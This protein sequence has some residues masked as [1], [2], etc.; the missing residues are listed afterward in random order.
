[1]KKTIAIITGS[2]ADYSHLRPI[3]EKITKEP[4]LKCILYVTGDHL[5]K[6]RGYSADEIKKDGFFAKRIVLVNAKEKSTPYDMAKLVGSLILKFSDAFLQDK[7]DAVLIMGDRVESFAAASTASLM[8]IPILHIG[9]GDLAFA[10]I[11]NTLR[12]AITKLANVHFT[13]SKKSAQRLLKMGEERWRIHNVGV[14]SLDTILK[15]KLLSKK[16]IS[17]RLQIPKKDYLL[18]I[19]H[20]TTSEW[21]MAGEQF[22][23]IIKACVQ[24]V[25][26]DTSIV[27]FL[28]NSYSGADKIVSIILKYKKHIHVIENRPHG[29]YLSLLRHAL[30]MVGNSSSGIVEAASL[31]VGVVDVGNRQKFREATIN[32]LHV[33]FSTEEI[34]R[35]IRKV[36]YD[37]HFKRKVKSVK[38][39]YGQGNASQK[40][41]KVLKKLKINDTLLKKKFI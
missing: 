19:F 31:R 3:L 7:P 39:P 37:K 10:D 38:S 21:Q 24:A 29:E 6:S 13:H 4:T 33:N 17:S 5:L 25:T 40:I 35:A 26:A 12:H 14:V 1:M 23:A 11:D 18:V 41:L 27:V 8:N 36:L 20:P 2:R 30:A 32:V 34:E 22:K 16:E 9:G 28:P 15:A